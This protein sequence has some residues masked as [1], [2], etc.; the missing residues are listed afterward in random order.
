MTGP[1]V[2][3]LP[4]RRIVRYAEHYRTCL[5]LGLIKILFVRKPRGLPHLWTSA[6]YRVRRLYLIRVGW[7]ASAPNRRFRSAS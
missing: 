2:G 7:S 3:L 6:D 4:A 1:V 5:S